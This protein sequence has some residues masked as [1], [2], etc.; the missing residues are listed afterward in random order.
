M[1][2]FGE[3][4]FV[5][6]RIDGYEAARCLLTRPAAAALARVQQRSR[7]AGSRAQGLR[8]LP[9]DARGGAF[10]ALG[11]RRQG[12]EAQGRFLS[13]RRQARP[14]P[15]RL[16][17]EPLRPFARLDRRPHAGAACARDSR[18]RT[19]T[20]ARASISSA[21]NPGRRAAPSAR[22]R[23]RTGKSSPPRCGAAASCR[24]TRNGGT[25]RCAASRIRRR[26][27]IFVVK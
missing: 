20:W 10:R 3:D 18:P 2:Y 11:A 15:A 14:V 8:L 19:S 4:N 23:R 22:R 12:R 25:S 1:R 13:R 6:A 24:T 27:S 26:I 16:Y 9:A 5:G 17:L 21:C 7:A